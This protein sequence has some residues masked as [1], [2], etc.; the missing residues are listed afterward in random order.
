MKKYNY[1][2]AVLAA[3]VLF[4]F[5]CAKDEGNYTY[6]D[7]STSFVDTTAMKRAFFVKQNETV[8][9]DVVNTPEAPGNLAYEWRLIQQSFTPDPATGIF[10][11]KQVGTAKK[12]SYKVIDAP[13][14]YML[15]LYVKDNANGGITQIVKMP[16]TIGSYASPGWMILHGDNTS[17]D[18]S[19]I[20][21]NKLLGTLL[22]P[23]TD[24]VQP[25][26][27]SETNGSKVQGEGANVIYMVNHWVDVF[28]KTNQGGYRVSGDDL[29]IKNTYSNM[30]INPLSASEIEYQA[31]AGW[32]YNEL[33]INKGGLYFI[34]QPTPSVYN[35]FGV[36][37]FG[38]DYVA[39]PFIG[40]IFSG[41][42]YGV[43]YDM[44]NKRFLFVDFQ[45]NVKKFKPWPGGGTAKFDMNNVGKE[46][47]YAEHGFAKGWFCVM[48]DQANPNSR[49]LFVC[50]FD[51]ADDGFRGLDRINI[52]TATDLNNAKFFAFGNK[53][54]VMYY[55][56]DTKIY[57]NDYSGSKLS[58]LSYDVTT[59][60]PGNVITSMKILKVTT[61]PVHPN[62]GKLLYV[63]LYN[64]STKAGTLLQIDVNEVSGVFGAVKAYTGFGKISGMNYKIK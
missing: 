11:S 41:T 48:Q 27:L 20:V 50:N 33:L 60:Y 34:P 14:S 24:Y 57:Q 55:A 35:Q 18:I 1:C 6:K 47:V 16:F 17:C 64:P 5:G 32:S 10:F 53:A 49:E 36:R 40:T 44:G 8:E 61:N 28:T 25:N 58:T 29:R 3:I 21:N 26:V 31:Y 38:E 45:R 52:S 15:V 12:L 54:N 51:K 63:A 22:P 13:G 9:Q 46:M 43:I 56:T 42:Y 62:D 19:I 39:A 4:L 37:C 59:S 30:F 23:N 2:F 7:L